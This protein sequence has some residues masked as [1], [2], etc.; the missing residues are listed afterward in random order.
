MENPLTAAAV[1]A[2]L[3]QMSAQ[4][5]PVRLLSEM[6]T[7][8]QR[9]VAS[10]DRLSTSDSAVTEPALDQ[11]LSSLRTAWNDGEIR[12][13]AKPRPKQKR[14]RRRPDPLAEVTHERRSWFEEEP[15]QT[16]RELLARLQSEYPEKYPDLL[17]RTLQRRVTWGKEKAHEMVFG[18]TSPG[19]AFRAMTG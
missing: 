13:T 16:S 9:L 19:T 12:P 8:Q 5:D 10:A 14:E 17:L 4:L 6:R 7:A 11:F 18:T 15:W 2:K 1:R 3:A